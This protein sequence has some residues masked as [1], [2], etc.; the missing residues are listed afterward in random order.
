M[1]KSKRDFLDI[2][3]SIRKPTPPPDKV[4]LSEK[5]I[6]KNERFDWRKELEE[7]DDED[8]YKGVLDDK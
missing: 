5:D 4:I 6:R 2:Y 3:R 8:D 1:K 7:M